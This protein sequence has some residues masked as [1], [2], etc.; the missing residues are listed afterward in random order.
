MFGNDTLDFECP[1]CGHSV[2]AKTL[3]ALSGNLVVECPGCHQSISVETEPGTEM[4]LRQ[5][6]K[7][8]RELESRIK[9]LGK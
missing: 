9:K 1:S 7:S 2:T 8:L 4:N 6:D 3:E 5:A